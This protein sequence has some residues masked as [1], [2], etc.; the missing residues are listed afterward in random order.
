VLFHRRFPKIA[1]SRES[2]SFKLVPGFDLL[3][4]FQ[5]YCYQSIDPVGIL[6][7]S[8]VPG[9]DSLLRLRR[10][11][12]YFTRSIDPNTGFIVRD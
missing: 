9:F 10:F 5:K 12:K 1:T 7:V 6:L 2:F 4:L 11:P 3:L 8:A